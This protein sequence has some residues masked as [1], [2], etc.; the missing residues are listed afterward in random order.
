IREISGHRYGVTDVKFSADGNY[1][2]ST[3]RDTMLL[4]CEVSDGKEVAA[5]GKSR[6][7]QFKDWLYALAIS[8]DQNW[9]AATDIAGL[10]HVWQLS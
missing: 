3:G 4:I 8:P 9:V 10:V 1:D 2:L 7:G 5:L 6:G